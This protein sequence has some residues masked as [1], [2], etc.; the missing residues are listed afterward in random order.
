MFVSTNVSKSNKKRRARRHIKK[1]SAYL[2]EMELFNWEKKIVLKIFE[3]GVI[4]KTNHTW[5]AQ[6]LAIDDPNLLIVQGHT[7]SLLGYD[8]VGCS[9]YD[10]LLVVLCIL[11]YSSFSGFFFKLIFSFSSNHEFKKS[12]DIFSHFTTSIL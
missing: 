12:L 11:F 5:A 2:V 8:G 4:T 7:S 6:R 1:S 9:V 10:F 3:E